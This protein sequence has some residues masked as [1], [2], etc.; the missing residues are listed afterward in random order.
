MSA[1]NS[2]TRANFVFG[3]AGGLQL[4]VGGESARVRI[5]GA[6]ACGAAV[7]RK[8][9][10]QPRATA[11]YLSVLDSVAIHAACESLRAAEE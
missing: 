10:D 11:E 7:G 8:I 5:C 1:D 3:A 9:V 4:A 6:V 2:A